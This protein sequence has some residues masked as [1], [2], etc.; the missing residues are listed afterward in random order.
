MN[1]IAL[2][3]ILLVAYGFVVLGITVKKPEKVWSMG[4]IQLFIKVL[5]EKGTVLF[6]YVFGVAAIGFGIWLML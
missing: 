2:L 6:F 5:G 3:G 4:K 1:G